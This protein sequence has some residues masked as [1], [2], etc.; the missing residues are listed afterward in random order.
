VVTS[1]LTHREDD[2]DD[3]EDE[4]NETDDRAQNHAQPGKTCTTQG[5]CKRRQQR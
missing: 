4:E 2:K 1:A 5:L 3:E